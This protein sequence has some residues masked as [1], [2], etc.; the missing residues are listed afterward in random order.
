VEELTSRDLQAAWLWLFAL[1]AL[2]LIPWFYF[3]ALTGMVGE[4]GN[5]LTIR[6]Y[7]FLA[8]IWAYPLTLIIALVFR[9]LSRALIL[10]P[11]LQVVS[12]A[13]VWNNSFT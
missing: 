6:D 2:C 7:L 11:L 8:W 10:L 13:I 1:L 9:R 3:C 4:S 12:F 5:P